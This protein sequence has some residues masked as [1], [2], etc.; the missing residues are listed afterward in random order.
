MNPIV[1]LINLQSLASGDNLQLKVYKFIGKNQ[2][3]KAYIQANLHGAEIVGNMV[4]YE[5]VNFLSSLNEEQIQGEI[6]LVPLCNPAGVN[7]RYSFFS[8]GRYNP[9]DGQNWNRIFWDFVDEKPDLDNFVTDNINQSKE[10]IQHKYFE[11]INNKFN[12]KIKQINQQRGVCFSEHYRNILQSL[13]LSANYVIDIHSSSVKAIDYL[14]CFSSR[15]KSADYFLLDYGILMNQYDGH[16][17]DEAFLNP[18]L[19]LEKKFNKYARNILFDVESW[20]LELGSGM[21]A[22]PESVKRGINGIINYLI[23]KNILKLD[24]E[25]KQN[26]TILIPKNR[27]KFYYAPKGGIIRNR[28]SI[29]TKINVGDILYQILSFNKKEELPTMIEIKS[30]DRGLIF[31]TSLNETVSQG[32]YVLGIFPDVC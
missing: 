29:N 12:S 13:C 14:Y 23:A 31:D 9:Y 16:A 32:E 3:K 19:V 18:W 15:E 2:G 28:L 7:Q 5:L 11:L 30:Q 17:F 6:S 26:N 8:T 4:I 10:L 24:G 22:N 27:I 1:E 25:I 20:T 21:V